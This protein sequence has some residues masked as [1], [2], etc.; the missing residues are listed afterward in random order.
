MDIINTLIIGA[1]ASGCFSSIKLKE[2][3]IDCAIIE[4]NDRILKKLLVTGNGRC[5]VSNEK[6][7]SDFENYYSSIGGYDYSVFNSY[8]FNDTVK[9]FENLGIPLVKLE[10]G[11]I[12][13]RSL[14]AASVV[15]LIKLRIEELEIP[16]FLSERVKDISLKN[17]IYNVV[18]DK[19]VHRSKNVI[20][21]TG[22]MA[23]P[24]TGSDGSMF[25]IMK[26]LGINQAKPLPA[27]VQLKLDSRNLK[28]L[29]GV[30]FDGYISLYSGSTLTKK[31]FGEI[32]FTDYG[33]SGPPVLQLSRFSTQL[34]SE[35]HELFISLNLIPEKTLDELRQMLEKRIAKYPERTA[36]DLLNAIVNKKIIPVI[37]KESGI[38]KMTDKISE[39]PPLVLDTLI[40][41]LQNWTFKVIGDN[42]FANAQS[43]LGGILMSEVDKFTLESKKYKGLYFSGEILDVCG[44]C[45]GYNL[46]WA[47]SSSLAVTESIIK[48]TSK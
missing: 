36:T 21:A 48:T 25:R 20:V 46:Q 13:P 39:I 31:E 41:K 17:G 12:Y 8:N 32:L 28:A 33:I 26:S 19:S 38:N 6:I 23:M 35:N 40:E 9:D 2:N 22:G 29:S 44:A 34:L 30:K 47:W 43:T 27:L 18:T 16:V 45:G 42:G 15:D 3:N 4:A 5:N 37:S 24:S 7:I 11:K 14:Q 10:D 1:G